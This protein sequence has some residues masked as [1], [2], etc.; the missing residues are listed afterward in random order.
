MSGIRER[1]HAPPPVGAPRHPGACGRADIGRRG[2]RPHVPRRQPDSTSRLLLFG[3]WD[4]RGR[5]ESDLGPRAMCE[6]WSER[7][8]EVLATTQTREAK[9]IAPQCVSSESRCPNR[10][11]AWAAIIVNST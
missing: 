9:A 4:S 8:V 6:G 10:Q 7:E 11:T 2:G 3:R 1:A 5:S